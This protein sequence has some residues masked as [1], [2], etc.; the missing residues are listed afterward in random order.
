MRRSELTGE[1]SLPPSHLNRAGALGTVL[2][3]PQGGQ[4]SQVLDGRGQQPH[5]SYWSSM[6]A[7]LWGHLQSMW[8]AT[9]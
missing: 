9:M 2:R 5:Y 3:T 1:T 8:M 7:S 4:G 6:P